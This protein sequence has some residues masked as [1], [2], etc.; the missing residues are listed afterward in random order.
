MEE[1]G[2]PNQE[3]LIQEQTLTPFRF[4]VLTDGLGVKE[5]ESTLEKG[6]FSEIKSGAWEAPKKDIFPTFQAGTP[7]E[8][9]SLAK[10]YHQ[11]AEVQ[12]DEPVQSLEKASLGM[13]LVAWFVDTIFLIL[14]M[15]IAFFL[16]FNQQIELSKA[17]VYFIPL[18]FLT[19]LSYGVL[20][21]CWGK[22]TLG[23]RLLG[24]QLVNAHDK[25]LGI[26]QYLFR[27]FL[28]LVS[29]L[30]LGVPLITHL[31]DF[32]S[33]TSLIHEA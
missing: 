24:L 5:K 6:L 1:C 7:L 17:L 3:N 28:I 33:G 4:R 2:M 32:L 10:F 29:W 20:M 16:L 25:E 30:A 27:F 18:F 11:P 19:Q 21:D 12:D 23:K 8:K 15:G 13:R 31:Q 22:G 9:G 26:D 14:F